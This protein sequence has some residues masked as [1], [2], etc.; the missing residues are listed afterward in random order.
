MACREPSEHFVRLLSDEQSK[1]Y[2][3]VLAIVGDR[4]AAPDVFQNTNVALWRKASEFV[5]GTDFGAWSRRVA[6]FEVLDYRK[7]RGRERHIFDDALLQQVAA[8]VSNQT[9]LLEAELATLH[10]CMGL[11]PNVDH[12]LIDARYARGESVAALAKQRGKTANAIS[13]AL[14]R[15][16]N[17]LAR[18]IEKSLGRERRL[19]DTNTRQGGHE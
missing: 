2:A 19:R 11:L 7:R 18:C 6:F 14:Y 16:R 15:I 8:E 13:L 3:Y 17:E 9:D 12:A 1:L 5:E 4:N 10:H